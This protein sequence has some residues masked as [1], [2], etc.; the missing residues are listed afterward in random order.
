MAGRVMQQALATQ[1]GEDTNPLDQTGLCLLSLDGGGVRG[2]S[3][4]YVLKGLMARL[5][6][7][8]EAKLL[9][10]VKPCEVFD[11]IGG[12]STGG[13]VGTLFLVAFADAA[14]LIAI[15]LGRL[16][17]DVDECI[18]AYEDLM[19]NVFEEKSRRVPISWIG[20]TKAKF[21]SGKLKSA[22]EKVITSR[23][24]HQADL[25]NDGTTRGCRV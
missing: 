8:L 17:M 13:Y 6:R 14:R 2:L 4:L 10:P 19:K 23:G 22:I 1:Q 15:M 7:E 25:F 21:D 3:T 12:T 18:S 11:L 9:P 5:N 24:L 20:N 16:E